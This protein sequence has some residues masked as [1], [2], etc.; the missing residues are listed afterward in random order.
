MSLDQLIERSKSMGYGEIHVCLKPE[1]GLQAFVVIH[2]TQRGP[3]L[4]GCRFIEYASGADAVVDALRL[5]QGMSYKAA[6]AG[7][8]Y[9]GGKAVLMRPTSLPDRAAL[10][11]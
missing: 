1:V 7:L 3:A 5:G 11:H 4:G 10:F 9:G 8:H 6:M 2:S